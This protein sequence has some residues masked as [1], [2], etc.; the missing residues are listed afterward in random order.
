MWWCWWRC[1]CCCYC[2]CSFFLFRRKRK[3]RSVRV[4]TPPNGA[5]TMYNVTGPQGTG[6]DGHLAAGHRWTIYVV[7]STV[8]TVTSTELCA[9]KPTGKEALNH[10]GRAASC[11]VQPQVP[12]ISFRERKHLCPSLSQHRATS[13][14]RRSPSWVGHRRTPTIGLLRTTLQGKNQ[15]VTRVSA[16]PFQVTDSQLLP[17]GLPAP[18]KRLT[19]RRKRQ[20]IPLAAAAKSLCHEQEVFPA[21]VRPQIFPT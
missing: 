15:V 13:T 14:P 12:K 17:Q 18:L 7:T 9:S 2:R 1:C 6:N 11:Q 10:H 4:T 16:K 5:Q 21:Q 19:L 3:K 8:A 20:G